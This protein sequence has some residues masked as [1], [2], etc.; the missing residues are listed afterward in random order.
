[1]DLKFSDNEKLII[2]ILGNRKMTIQEISEEFYHSKEQPLEGQNYVASVVRRITRKTDK[3]KL[4]W[5]LNG[6]GGGRGG[7][8]IWKQKR[9]NNR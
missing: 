9:T 7:R 6:K 1:M 2:H 5:T 3:M 8:T 4:D